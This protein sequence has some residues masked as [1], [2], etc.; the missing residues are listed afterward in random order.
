MGKAPAFRFYVRDW[1]ND[2]QLN[3]LILIMSVTDPA[4]SGVEGLTLS[5]T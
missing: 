2:P 3:P 5:E 4:T 1:L